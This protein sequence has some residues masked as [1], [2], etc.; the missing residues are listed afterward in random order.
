MRGRALLAGMVAL[1]SLTTSLALADDGDGGSGTVTAVVGDETL[2]TGTRSVTG[3][4]PVIALSLLTG[5]A[6]MNGP[7]EIVVTEAA[8]TGT[9]SWSVTAQL[10]ADLSDGGSPAAT[11][12]RSNLAIATGSDPLVV[13]GGGTSSAGAGGSLEAARTVFSN[14]GQLT[15]LNYTGTYTSTSTVTLNIPNAQKTGIYTGTLTVSLVQ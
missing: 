11:I 6:N 13:G 3:V 5:T 10:A 2:I 12:P 8:R 1:F 4:T 15:G 14:S 7:V 9:A